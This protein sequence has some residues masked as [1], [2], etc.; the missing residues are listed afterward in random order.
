MEQ[1]S[2]YGRAELTGQNFRLLLNSQAAPFLF[3]QNWTSLFNQEGWA[4]ELLNQRKDGTSYNVRLTVTP[5][6][7]TSGIVTGYVMVQSDISQLKEVE[8]L[9]AEFISNV[10]HDLRTPLT[11]IKTHLSL[12]E[13][14][15]P[16]NFP[17][18]FQVMRQATDHLNRL[19]QDLLDMSRL[20]A[21]FTP[22]LKASADLW[23]LFNELQDYFA[24]SVAEKGLRYTVKGTPASITAVRMSQSH[25]RL[26]LTHLIDN[27]IKYS[28]PGGE[29]C[30]T[31]QPQTRAN[32]A[33]ALVRI[34]DEGPGLSQEEQQHIFDRFYRGEAARTANIAG[35]GLGL[36]TVKKIVE[37]Y[38]GLI[39]AENRTGGGA[40]FLL[41]LPLTAVL[42]KT[43]GS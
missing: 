11:I 3:V 16:E 33:F 36:P 22:E 32:R 10:T 40:C 13:R 7:E 2:G 34:E 21:E 17:R 29:I 42:E 15:K 27:A 39:E 12:L 23:P 41:W 8:R 18:Y 5:I 28:I 14:G 38:G 19:I 26:I 24:G 1:M 30:I 31:V 6:K 4:R 43:D 20:D 9:K 35:S 25:L 37:P